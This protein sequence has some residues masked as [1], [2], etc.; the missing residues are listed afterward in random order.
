MTKTTLSSKLN[1]KVLAFRNQRPLH[2]R[3][4]RDRLPSQMYH[5]LGPAS[6]RNERAS[7]N[8]LSHNRH[9]QAI[10]QGLPYKPNESLAV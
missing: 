7:S 2:E 4:R 3:S 8:A 6:S 1:R 10:I 9:I 5:G